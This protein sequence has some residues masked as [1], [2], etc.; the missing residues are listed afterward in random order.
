MSADPKTTPGEQAE[1]HEHHDVQAMHSPIMRELSD[2][3]EGY[4]AIN[5]LWTVVFGFLLFFGGWYL[6]KYGGDFG[7]DVFDESKPVGVAEPPKPID[8]LVLGQ[9]LYAGKCAACHQP[10]GRGRPGQFPPLAG[11]DWVAGEPEN[12]IRI[13]LHGLQGPVTVSGTSYNG[14]MPAFR[15]QM[16]DEQVAAVLSFI[17]QEWG[18]TGAA[19]TAEQVAAVRSTTTTRTAPWKEVDFKR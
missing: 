10:D 1:H 3:R 5:P 14:N 13:V 16:K 7:S 2:P 15:E 11:S 17:R 12:L 6:G 9:R 4:E 8:P 19:V 18:N